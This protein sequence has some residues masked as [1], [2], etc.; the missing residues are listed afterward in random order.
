MEPI[1]EPGRANTSIMNGAT[2]KMKVLKLRNKLIYFMR[3]I[4]EGVLY[5]V[6]KAKQVPLMLL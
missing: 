3:D 6:T 2:V 1:L 4:C 5:G